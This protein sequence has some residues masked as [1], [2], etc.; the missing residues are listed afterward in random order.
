MPDWI[1]DSDNLYQTEP[2]DLKAFFNLLFQ[3]D[4]S[5]DLFNY[6]W[7]KQKGII[8]HFPGHPPDTCL[9]KNIDFMLRFWKY[10]SYYEEPK[11]IVFAE[12]KWQSKNISI[13]KLKEKSKSLSMKFSD[14]TI[15]YKG[16]SIDDM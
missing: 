12:V 10:K 5:K 15:E 13:T 16:L 7:N 11:V 3:P 6:L 4:F 1:P 14:Y 8:L 2:S 9:H